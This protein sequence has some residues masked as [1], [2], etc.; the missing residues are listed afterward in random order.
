MSALLAAV[1]AATATAAAILAAPRLAEAGARARHGG[2]GGPGTGRIAFPLLG[3]SLSDAALDAA[4]RV[5]RAQEATLVPIY[6]AT[7]PLVLPL[8]APLPRQAERALTLLEAIEQRAAAAQV[9]VD[10]RIERGRS[11]RHALVV[12]L[13]QEPFARLV[14]PAETRP[15]EGFAAG[16][17][18]WLLEHVRE[19]I[20]VVRPAREAA[21]A[22]AAAAAVAA[23]AA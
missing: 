17:I 3:Q 12:A 18:A 5:A 22:A 2:P 8:Q 21:P 13:A 9:P 10:A 15:G 19:E 14:L 4:L 23:A 16:D 1:L 20:V 11:P 7:V 6:L